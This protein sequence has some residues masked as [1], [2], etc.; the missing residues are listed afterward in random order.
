MGEITNDRRSN[1][2]GIHS[3]GTQFLSQGLSLSEPSL[4][5]P[6]I[7]SKVLPVRDQPAV[8]MRTPQP[9]LGISSNLN[10]LASYSIEL[11]SSEPLGGLVPE[12]RIIGIVDIVYFYAHVGIPTGFLFH[13]LAPGLLG[14]NLKDNLRCWSRSTYRP[15][16]PILR[17]GNA[18]NHSNIWRDRVFVRI[19]CLIKV[20]VV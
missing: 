17:F 10:H 6:I 16:A 13:I 15:T 11:P 4:I 1:F 2:V 14:G 19:E 5:I 20:E 3:K 8:Q 7:E 18:L 9:P 12:G